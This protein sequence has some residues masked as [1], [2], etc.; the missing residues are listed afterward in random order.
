MDSV[1]IE[2][3]SST[4]QEKTDSRGKNQMSQTEMSA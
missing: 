4:E 2:K 1:K 3:R